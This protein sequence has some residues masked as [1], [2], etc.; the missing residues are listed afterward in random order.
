M[1]NILTS[2]ND[3]KK[4]KNRLSLVTVGHFNS[5]KSTLLGQLLYK[6]GVIPKIYL[7]DYERESKQLFREGFKFAYVMDKDKFARESGVTIQNSIAYMETKK[8]EVCLIDTPGHPDFAINIIKAANSKDACL[9]VIS[10]EEF[11][12]S[13]KGETKDYPLLMFSLGIRQLII[14]ISKLDLTNPKYSENVFNNVVSQMIPYLLKIGF[15]KENL[16]FVPMSGIVGDNLTEKSDNLSWFKGPTLIEAINSLKKIKPN[17]SEALRFHAFEKISYAKVK[18]YICISI[19]SGT[20]KLGMKINLNKIK[21]ICT[22][23]QVNTK[24]LTEAYTGE[25]VLVQLEE[26][27]DDEVNENDKDKGSKTNHKQQEKLKKKQEKQE[28]KDADSGRENLFGYNK[29]FK[30]KKVESFNAQLLVTNWRG[31]YTNKYVPKVVIGG[32]AFL[33]CKMYVLKRSKFKTG[34][35]VDKDNVVKDSEPFFKN[36]EL[37]EVKFTPLKPKF[38]IEVY[39]DNPNLGRII[40][41]DDVSTV[42]VGKVLSVEYKPEETK[43]LKKKDKK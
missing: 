38:P 7:D 11:E 1:E 8:Y 36:C 12:D 42:C 28:R 33:N 24:E 17:E 9:L 2:K 39:N 10:A 43:K 23:I 18:K 31:K 19:T 22:S 21:Y 35:S 16:E 3:E 26:R 14:G 20:L 4:S 25:I 32:S 41:R 29:G 27:S 13:F 37:V 40:V 6:V 34:E 5:G 30:V 15:Q